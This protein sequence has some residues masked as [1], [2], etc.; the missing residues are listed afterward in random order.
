MAVSALIKFVQG[1]S[2]PPAG[3]ALI[4]VLTTPVTCSNGDN[5]NVANFEWEMIDRP[6]G[7][8]V[9]LGIVAVGLVP[10][11]MFIPDVRGGYHLHL[12]TM[13][14]AGNQAEDFRVFQVPEVSGHVIPPLDA[15]QAALNFGA[16]SRG[17]AKYLEDLLRF[18][19]GRV[20]SVV[21]PTTYVV[22]VDE[23]TLSVT[24]SG[25]AVTVTLPA[26]PATGRRLDIK[27]AGNNAAANNITIAGNGKTI[28][29]AASLIITINR[30]SRT[31]RY[32]GTEWMILGS[33]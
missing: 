17:W 5:S 8:V 1:A 23:G 15:V 21:G 27:D 33:F 4:G 16:Q 24:T 25:G 32:N 19:L 28:D 9:P 18:V 20:V 22:G 12:T 11:F 10:T 14:L 13:D 30:G 31:I 29:G 26:S 7:S 2:T 6:P 3:E